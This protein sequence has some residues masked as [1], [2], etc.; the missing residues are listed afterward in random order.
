MSA[1]VLRLPNGMYFSIVG[2]HTSISP[3]STILRSENVQQLCES[4]DKSDALF[5]FG[6]DAILDERRQ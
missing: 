5:D 3:S 6:V 1:K 2:S 4:A